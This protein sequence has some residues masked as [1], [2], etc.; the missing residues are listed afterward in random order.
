L[1]RWIQCIFNGYSQAINWQLRRRGTLFN[2][3]VIKIY[4]PEPGDYKE[5]IDDY[6][7]EQVLA[8]K[9]SPYFLD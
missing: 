8:A 9:M 7:L 3:D 2:S 4:F 6:G 5:D 1:S